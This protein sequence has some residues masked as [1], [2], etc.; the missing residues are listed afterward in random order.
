MTMKYK[1]WT[2]LFQPCAGTDVNLLDITP[3]YAKFFIKL[4][5]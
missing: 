3:L 5:V 2:Y 1:F 4:F